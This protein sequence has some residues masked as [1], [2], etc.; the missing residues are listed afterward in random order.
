MVDGGRFDWERHASRFPLLTAPDDAHGGVVWTQTGKGLASSLGRSSYLLKMRET[1]LRDLGPCLSP[2][3]AFLLIQGLQTLP[4]RTRAHSDNALVVSRFVS[5][6]PKVSRVVHPSLATGD[7]AD[8]VARYLNGG[9]G[10]LVFFELIGGRSMGARFVEALRLI[11]HVTN[12]GDVRSYATHP[13]STTHAQLPDAQQLAAGVT[14]GGVRLAVGLEH[15]D[16]LLADLS[17]VSAIS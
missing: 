8:R 9:Y 1:L 2:F 15:P 10:P 3:N 13:A 16:D 12:R 6:H 7:E 4:L 11:S 5:G 17:Q 14:Q